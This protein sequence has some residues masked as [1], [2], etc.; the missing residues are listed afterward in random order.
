MS[1][2]KIGRWE[3]KIRSTN[4]NSCYIELKFLRHVEIYS[5]VQSCSI[6]V[7]RETKKSIVNRARRKCYYR[8]AGKKHLISERIDLLLNVEENRKKAH[9]SN[10]EKER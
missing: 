4:P 6:E 9:E 8:R 7:I 3:T 2:E 1:N 5:F 10:E